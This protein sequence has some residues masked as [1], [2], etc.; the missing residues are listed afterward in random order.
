MLSVYPEY[1]KGIVL[2]A[3]SVSLQSSDMC[4]LPASIIF[5]SFFPG[6]LWMSFTKAKKKKQFVFIS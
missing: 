5:I 2:I 4:M 3:E 1:S 6:N